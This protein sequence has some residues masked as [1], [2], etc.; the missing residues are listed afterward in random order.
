VVGFG[1]GLFWFFKGFRVY[2]ESRV[3]ADTPEIPIR[4]MAISG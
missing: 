4:S 3:L 2:R 1:V